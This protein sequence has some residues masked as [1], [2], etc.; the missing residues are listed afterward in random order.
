LKDGDELELGELRLKFFYVPGH[1]ED[2][3]VVYEAVHELLITGDL[4]FVGKVG[5]T[6]SDGDALAEWSSLQRVLKL[7]PHTATVWPGHDYGARP[8]STLKLELA[9]NPFLQCADVAEF[10]ALKKGWSEFKKRNGLK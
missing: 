6:N 5:G 8:S 3:L 1:C 10:M 7:V 9:S 2:H 4:L